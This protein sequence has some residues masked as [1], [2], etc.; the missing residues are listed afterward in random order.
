MDEFFRALPVALALLLLAPACAH[1]ARPLVAEDAS[2]LAR[3][4]CQL[5]TWA[6]HNEGNHEYWVSPHCNPGGSWELIA[7]IGQ[8]SPADG[9][10]GSSARVLRAK[11]VMRPVTRNSW[12]VGIV[13]TDQFEA[14]GSVVGDLAVNLPLSVSLRDDRVRLHANAGWV[15]RRDGPNGATWALGGEWN[16]A[17]GIGITLDAYGAAHGHGW[18]QAGARYDLVPS[19]A[20]LDAAVGNRFGLRGVERYVAVG[21]TITAQVWR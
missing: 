16:V 13:L 19:R 11:T 10:A 7:G 17:R 6:Q 21:L 12:G 9:G 4:V 20:T 5:E 14:G 1:A 3:G 8:A 15:R 2:I 18:V